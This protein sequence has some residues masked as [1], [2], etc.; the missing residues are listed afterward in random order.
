MYHHP[1][2]QLGVKFAV[3]KDFFPRTEHLENI[4]YHVM[5]TEI[6]DSQLTTLIQ[7]QLFTSVCTCD[8]HHLT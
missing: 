3:S 4:F 7:Q 8:M 5:E 1:A 6:I 2:V